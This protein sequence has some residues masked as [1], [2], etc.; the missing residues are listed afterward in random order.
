[1]K[2]SHTFT[3]AAAKLKV[4]RR[5]TI[6]TCTTIAL[7]F[8]VVIFFLT[9]YSSLFASHTRMSA[10]IFDGNTFII[11]S[12]FRNFNTVTIRARALELYD[13]SQDEDKRYPLIEDEWHEGEFFLDHTNK[14][15]IQASDE[16]HARLMSEQHITLT[17]VAARYNGEIIA[18]TEGL[19][20]SSDL[21]FPALEIPPG[22]QGAMPS[23]V[24]IDILPRSVVNSLIAFEPNMQD[25]VPVIIPA[26]H[27]ARLLNLSRLPDDA[28]PRELEARL[29][30]IHDRA[31]GLIFH[32]HSTD[33][34]FG[35][36]INDEIE[37][38]SLNSSEL[39]DEISESPT[40]HIT[41]QV[42][43]ISAGTIQPYTIPG[44]SGFRDERPFLLR[45]LDGIN[46][47]GGGAG[48]IIPTEFINDYTLQYFERS[49]TSWLGGSTIIRFSRPADLIDFRANEF[50]Y[51]DNPHCTLYGG[52]QEFMSSIY[53]LHTMSYNI[54]TGVVYL[55]AFLGFIAMFIMAG[56]IGR[57][58]EDEK[59][60]T[61]IY[62][63]VGAT[64]GA[65]RKIY[66][67]Y[68]TLLSAITATLA[69]IIGYGFSLA[70]HIAYSRILTAN[71]RVTYGLPEST[72]TI[73]TVG[74]DI[75]TLLV[76]GAIFLVGLLC[77]LLC[78]D[79]MIS[80]SIIKDIKD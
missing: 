66:I 30:D 8:G 62:R 49:Y 55:T 10:E 9:V 51:D 46:S 47:F 45:V 28:S 35:V 65:I 44:P 79:R 78:F 37:E 80:K 59:Q 5:R 63:A 74:F 34:F 1:M 29:K 40:E 58:I 70:I 73:W 61:A 36:P 60:A 19:H 52:A 6:V 4:R 68:V 43:G 75:R 76:I 41:F 53:W 17:E 64:K 67:T 33:T 77:T 20:R 72:H 32:G 2:L 57:V 71:S 14:F 69:L 42:I 23:G 24:A 39:D 7:L 15:V 38:E 16:E 12:T 31:P 25:S 27:A 54:N 18:N 21:F 26:E 56:T 11:T 3:L 50:C 13:L 48:F 22:A